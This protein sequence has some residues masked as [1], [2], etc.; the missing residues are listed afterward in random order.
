MKKENIIYGIILGGV[1]LLLIYS[2]VSALYNPNTN[3]EQVL[4]EEIKQE[5]ASSKYE[6]RLSEGTVNIELIPEGFKD[7]KFYVD[8]KV[9][10]H[11]VALDQFNLKEIITLEIEGK[12]L[13]PSET[14]QLSGHH[15]GG[16]LVFETGTEPKSFKIEI[17]SIPDVELRTFEW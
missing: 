3:T 10:T 16:I 9:N 1:S 5:L 13:P 4:T 6:S 14:P 2:L 11:S 12:K 7:G 17:K 15:S 8:M